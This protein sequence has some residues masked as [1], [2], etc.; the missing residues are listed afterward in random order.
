MWSACGGLGVVDVV[1]YGGCCCAL[2]VYLLSFD[3]ASTGPRGYWSFVWF[4]YGLLFIWV[5]RL[6]IMVSWDHQVSALFL[7]IGALGPV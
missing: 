2:S 4:V 5:E 6:R 1:S 3:H 7:G